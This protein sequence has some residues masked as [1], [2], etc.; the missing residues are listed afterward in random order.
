M[1]V[2]DD[3]SNPEYLYIK[4]QR[5]KREHRESTEHTHALE[6]RNFNITQYHN[7][8]DK[9][10]TLKLLMNFEPFFFLNQHHPS[11]KK[12]IYT[13]FGKAHFT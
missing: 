9:T 13:E 6:K 7:S 12:Y 5:K 3:L 4:I 2:S 11:K 8:P 10:E 1:H